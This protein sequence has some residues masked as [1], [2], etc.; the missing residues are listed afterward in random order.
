MLGSFY[1]RG[2]A[3]HAL[4]RVQEQDRDGYERYFQTVSNLG[5]NGAF[6]KKA[7]KLPADLE[8]KGCHKDAEGDHFGRKKQKGEGVVDSHIDE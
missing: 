4:K 1:L 5:D 6:R 3:E 7:K 8:G 2:N